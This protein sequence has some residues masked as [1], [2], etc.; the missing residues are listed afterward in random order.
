MARLVAALARLAKSR[1]AM[2]RRPLAALGAPLGC[3]L[4]RFARSPGPLPIAWLLQWQSADRSCRDRCAR[5]A[6]VKRSRTG[7]P[8]GRGAAASETW[9]A[10][11]GRG[12][13]S[14]GAR[15][16]HRARR[17]YFKPGS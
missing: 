4:F 7:A 16:A 9:R 10:S 13:A 3:A 2:A 8:K 11:A 1:L 6:E 15:R 12:P 14:H 5:I 17:R